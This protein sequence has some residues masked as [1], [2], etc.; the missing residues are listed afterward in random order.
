MRKGLVFVLAAGF[1]AALFGQAPPAGA[2]DFHFQNAATVQEF[3]ELANLIRTITEIH[4]AAAD[5]VQ[6]TLHVN[7]SAEQAALAGWLVKELDQPLG[8]T[9]APAV[10]EYKVADNDVTRIV[11]LPHTMTVQAFQEAG[12]AARTVAEARRVF[13]YNDGRVM[14]VREAPDKVAMAAW[15]AGQLDAASDP[16]APKNEAPIEES[17]ASNDMLRVFPVTNAKSVQDFQEVVNAMRT[18]AEIRRVFSYNSA[19]MVVV[20]GTPE[21]IKMADWLLK[22]LDQPSG[23]AAGAAPEYR[24]PGAADDIVRVYHL[25]QVATVEEFQQE[26]SAV[27]SSAG[28]RRAFTYNAQRALTLRGTQ[29]QLAL[30]EVVM[31]DIDAARH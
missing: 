8:S 17:V 29:N 24:V 15:I 30:A 9:A 14:V 20:R 5:N 2:V 21:E 16:K 19:R 7:G 25:P 13:T 1:P 26:A 12:N 3:Q 28:I 22:Q 10:L 6:R 27:R 4:D 18:A 11:Y 31:R 23:A